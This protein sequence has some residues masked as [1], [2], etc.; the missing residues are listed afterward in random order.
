[1]KIDDLLNMDALDRDAT[2]A[3]TEAFAAA[4]AIFEQ[5]PDLTA[6][7]RKAILDR[8][9]STAFRNNLDCYICQE[10]DAALQRA[11]SSVVAEINSGS[12]ENDPFPSE[13]E[14]ALTPKEAARLLA[15]RRRG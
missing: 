13:G 7:E 11:V 3:A 15:A 1:L 12:E 10:A 2:V 4:L 8:E 9:L 6:L 14:L 5:S